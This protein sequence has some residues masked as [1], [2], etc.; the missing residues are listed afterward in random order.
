MDFNLDQALNEVFDTVRSGGV[1][2]RDSIAVVCRKEDPDS[3]E[4]DELEKLPFEE[5]ARLIAA[6]IERAFGSPESTNITGGS[7]LDWTD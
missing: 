2:R 6:E 3:K 7:I 1:A 4:W 5:D